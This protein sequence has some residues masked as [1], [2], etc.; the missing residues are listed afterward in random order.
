MLLPF[1]KQQ[2]LELSKTG[3]FKAPR[4][5]PT[6]MLSIAL[7]LGAVAGHSALIQ[8]FDLGHPAQD[9]DARVPAARS[10]VRGMKPAAP[11]DEAKPIARIMDS[12]DER[13]YRELFAAL[14]DGKLKEAEALAGE[15]KDGTLLGTAQAMFLLHPRNTN[16]KYSDVAGWLKTYSALPQAQD[17]YKKGLSLRVSGDEALVQPPVV[18]TASPAPS[19]KSFMADTLEWKKPR[20]FVAEAAWRAGKFD[21]VLEKLADVDVTE[22]ASAETYYSLWIK[23]LAAY[24][25]EDYATAAHSFMNVAKSDLAQANRTAAA[26]WAARSFEKSL[27]TEQASLYY[28]QA[29]MNVHSYYG[30]LAL[31]H[32][33]GAD[34]AVVDGWQEPSLTSQHIA[35]LKQDGAGARALALLQIGE[36]ELATKE[37][38]SISAKPGLQDA[39]EA[40]SAAAQLPLVVE[41]RNTKQASR[42][43]LMPWRPANGFI[44][45]PSL[46]M[47]I[48]W[49]ES[50]FNVR[51]QNPSGARGIM[52]I[53]PDTAEHIMPGSSGGLMNAQANVTLGD[54]YI[55]KLAAM[56]GIDGNLLLLI[57]GYNCGPGKVMQLYADA[58][59][60]SAAAK[61]PLLFIE[62]M[63]LK[64]TR[65]YVQKVLATYASYRLR[66]N[67]PL[68][69]MAS[70]SRGEWPSY[71]TTTRTA[72]K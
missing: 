71:E 45:D 40:L 28:E 8:D 65:D 6:M 50:K 5:I 59:R 49:N 12:D 1:T 54:L 61:D 22:R 68:G 33:A 46:V 3:Q 20:N 51:A 16:V 15:V 47:A 35:Q 60:N 11:R 42:Y 14:N 44:S 66:L 57:A 55:H 25:V 27:Q 64:E 41:P 56:N 2:L 67:K 24:A 30:M 23:G 4:L 58:Q 38:Q 37:L 34:N 52:Q 36:K 17:I 26:Y 9:G 13:T 72:S 69:A 39:L 62:T 10:M 53:M 31:A 63:P 19:Q 70:L 43:P 29:A 48:A 7:S 32:K 18:K 21:E